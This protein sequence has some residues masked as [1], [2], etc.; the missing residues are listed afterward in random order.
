MDDVPAHGRCASQAGRRMKI[1]SIELST[2]SLPLDPPFHASWDPRPRTSLSSTIVRIRAG[3]YEGVGSGDAMPGF[4]AS[5][6]AI[7]LR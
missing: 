6:A 5:S 7:C 2:Y 3:D 4:C 1:G